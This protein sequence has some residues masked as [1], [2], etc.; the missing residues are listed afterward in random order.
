MLQIKHF[1]RIKVLTQYILYII[2]GIV[3]KAMH[4]SGVKGY[5]CLAERKIL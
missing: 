3:S 5:R 1:T 4:K 2:I